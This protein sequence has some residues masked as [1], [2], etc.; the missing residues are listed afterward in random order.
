MKPHKCEV[1]AKY[2][3]VC[4]EEILIFILNVINIYQPFAKK[5]YYWKKTCK[6]RKEYKKNK[7]TLRKTRRL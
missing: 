6:A 2:L 1:C 4:R 7:E 5:E 3:R